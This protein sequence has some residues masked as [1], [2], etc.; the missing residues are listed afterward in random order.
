MRLMIWRQ[1]LSWSTGSP[2]E[3]LQKISHNRL[4]LETVPVI[5]PLPKMRP[6]PSGLDEPPATEVDRKSQATLKTTPV[7]PDQEAAHCPEVLTLKGY[8]IHEVIGKGTFSTVFKAEGP[9]PKRPGKIIRMACKVIKFA[10]VPPMWKA[11]A[12][13]NELKIR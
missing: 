1:P 6:A 4:R 11:S 5:G 3:S 8:D 2:T 12:L 10:V 7:S 13:N 9:D